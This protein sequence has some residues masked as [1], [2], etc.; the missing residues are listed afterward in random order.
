MSFTVND[1]LTEAQNLLNDSAATLFTNAVLQPFFDKSYAELNYK[2]ELADVNTNWEEAISMIIAASA[3]PITYTPLP[4]DFYSPIELHEKAVGEADNFYTLM[5]RTM[6]LP[7]RTIAPYLTWWTYREQTITFLGASQSREVRL[8]YNKIY[9]TITAV[10]DTVVVN[11]AKTYLS[12]RTAALAAFSIGENETRA[13]A[14]NDDASLALEMIVRLSNK[15]RQV[16][17]TRRRAFAINRG[18]LW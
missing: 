1:V 11:N 16:L 5:V 14:L 8:R 9:P 6:W 4:V 10:G 13:S 7:D 12:A 2:L 18:Y 15:N 3:V 17:R